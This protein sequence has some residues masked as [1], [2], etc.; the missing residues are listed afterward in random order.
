VRDLLIKQRTM[1][2]NQLRGLTAEFGVVAATGRRGPNELLA[3]LS[4]GEDRRIPSLLRDG[5]MAVMLMAVMETLRAIER[6]LEGID[7][8][9]V[10]AGRE[11]ATCRHLITAIHT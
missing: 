8:Q 10:G 2:T 6:R 3:I 9:I 1:L 4:D 11:D 7:R 5:L